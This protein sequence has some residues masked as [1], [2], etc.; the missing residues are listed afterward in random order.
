MSEDCFDI[1]PKRDTDPLEEDSLWDYLDLLEP[2][3][4]GSHCP[5]C[6]CPLE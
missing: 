3:D 1:L 6:G 4:D 2:Y 5:Y